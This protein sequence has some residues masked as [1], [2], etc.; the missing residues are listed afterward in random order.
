MTLPDSPVFFLCKI[1]VVVSIFLVRL[2]ELSLKKKSMQNILHV[3]S[4]WAFQKNNTEFVKG[5]WGNQKGSGAGSIAKGL[6]DIP[7]FFQVTLS[8]LMLD[9][10]AHDKNTKW[11]VTLKK[12]FIWYF[13]LKRVL[14]YQGAWKRRYTFSS[15]PFVFS[16]IRYLLCPGVI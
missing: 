11:K 9:F 3:Y 5:V 7:S 13:P 12:N 2:S 10:Y 14:F 1:T 16:K 4:G 8:L 15:F 6:P